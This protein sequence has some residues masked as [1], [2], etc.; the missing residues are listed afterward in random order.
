MQKK[1][2]YLVIKYLLVIISILFLYDK[3]KENYQF[4]L[5]KIDINIL[6][7][8]LIV[9]IKVISSNILSLRTFFFVKLTSNYTVELKKWNI[10]Y[11]LSSLINSSPLWGM[12]HFIRSYEMKKKNYSHK[13]YI[14]ANFF[15]FFWA[16]FINSILM[17]SLFIF[18]GLENY[19]ILFIFIVLFVISSSSISLNLI[20]ILF[21]SLQKLD[22][23]EIIKKF[24]LLNYLLIKILNIIK[25][26][27]NIFAKNIFINFVN[28]TILLFLLQYIIFFLVFN[29]FF[30]ISSLETVLQFFMLNYLIMRVP[31]INGIIGL[32]ET[33]LGIFSEYLGLIFLEGVVISLILRLLNITSLSLNYIFYY[34]LV[35]FN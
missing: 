19:Y 17:I 11:F 32:K 7:I 6:S 8:F 4:V 26:S 35:K 21:N 12:G 9:L 30:Q 24:K 1:N 27:D 14:S 15:I 22:T 33:I 5:E 2:L 20:N 10:L 13:E 3:S 29:F 34:L 28:F 25:V 16:I 18:T 31:S 23:F